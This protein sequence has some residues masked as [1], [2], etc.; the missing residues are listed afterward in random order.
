MAVLPVPIG[1]IS[2]SRIEEVDDAP[3]Y[4]LRLRDI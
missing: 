4:N 2:D 3:E 1:S